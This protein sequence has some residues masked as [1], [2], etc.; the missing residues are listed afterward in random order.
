VTSFAWPDT[1]PTVERAP[2]VGANKFLP[3]GVYG[4]ETVRSKPGTTMS[5]ARRTLWLRPGV[6][7]YH[8]RFR[9][10]K[11]DGTTGEA[12]LFSITAT[13]DPGGTVVSEHGTDVDG[14][15]SFE[16]TTDTKSL[17]STYTFTRSRIVGEKIAAALPSV[18]F[19]QDLQSPNVLQVSWAHGPFVDYREIPARKAAFPASVMEYLHALAT[20]QTRSAVPIRI[21]DLTTVTNG[22]AEAVKEAA[23]LIR[24]ETVSSEWTRFTWKGKRVAEAANQDEQEDSPEGE[25]DREIDLASHYQL[26]IIEPLIVSVGGQELTLGTVHTGLLSVRFVVEGEELRALPHLNDTMQRTFAPDDP[27]PDRSRR[28]VLG[29][30]LGAIDDSSAR[31][32]APT[33]HPESAGGD[34]ADAAPESLRNKI[35]IEGR[36]QPVSVGLV[37]WHATDENPG[38]PLAEVRSAALAT[39]RSLISDGLFELGD[40]ASNER[41]FVA[42]ERKLDES[43]SRIGEAD[44]SQFHTVSSLD[45]GPW[46]KLTD[47]GEQVAQQLAG[48][49]GHA[50]TRRRRLHVTAS[51]RSGRTDI[52]ERIDELLA[53]EAR[54]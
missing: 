39:I 20:L 35:I 22:D 36:T 5:G 28:P 14:F 1:V 43:M 16:S 2:R 32:Q 49:C 40:F 27:V 21:P 13:P 45:T 24:G 53:A 31:A 15:L 29:R 7:T 25:D 26:I 23:M 4:A 9:I 18:Q 6:Q 12:L 10:R 38:A 3:R 34:E 33:N 17:T 42:Y 19:I 50:P 11:P 41:R 52:S 54:Q 47:K 8:A 44:S 30:A 51:G 48:V 46:L 37:F